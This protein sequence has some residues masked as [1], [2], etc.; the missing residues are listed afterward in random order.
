MQDAHWIISVWSRLAS[1]RF[2]HNPRL[3][4]LSVRIC[5]GPDDSARIVG[6]RIPHICILSQVD[7]RSTEESPTVCLKANCGH[8]NQVA[9]TVGKLAFH[10]ALLQQ[11]SRAL[12]AEG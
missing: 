6:R 9:S 7:A 8:G 4:E 3:Q 12:A 11:L 2:F 10:S 1:H 5:V